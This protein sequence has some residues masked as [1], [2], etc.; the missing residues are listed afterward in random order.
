VTNT[1]EFSVFIKAGTVLKR[2]DILPGIKIA[3][4]L[5]D[6]EYCFEQ[7]FQ[8][9][10]VGDLGLLQLSPNP[11]ELPS[12]C[13]HDVCDCSPLD[14]TAADADVLLHCYENI[15]EGVEAMPDQTLI[16]DPSDY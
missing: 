6:S 1:T 9:G 8:E 10:L 5:M 16:V 14:Y 13:H 15:D 4:V 11:E 3:N 12:K 7:N 2:G